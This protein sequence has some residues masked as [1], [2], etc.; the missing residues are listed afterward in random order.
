M[1]TRNGT[2]KT[3]II[4]IYCTLYMDTKTVHQSVRDTQQK[5]ICQTKNRKRKKKNAAV[6]CLRGAPKSD[7]IKPKKN[8]YRIKKC[9]DKNFTYKKKHKRI[10][11]SLLFLKVVMKQQSKSE[12][13]KINSIVWLLVFFCFAFPYSFV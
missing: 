8:K 2:R 7:E 3:S 13:I 12:K 4:Q 9:T 6:L 10:K 5:T 11:E 1:R